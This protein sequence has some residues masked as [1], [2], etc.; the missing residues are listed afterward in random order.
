M[1]PGRKLDFED[2]LKQDFVNTGMKT[3][4]VKLC[5]IYI[6][7]AV[8]DLAPLKEAAEPRSDAPPA[9]WQTARPSSNSGLLMILVVIGAFSIGGLA[10]YQNIEMKKVRA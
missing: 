4:H 1:D 10:S 5:D 9:A 2:N 7:D 8:E 6:P 3:D